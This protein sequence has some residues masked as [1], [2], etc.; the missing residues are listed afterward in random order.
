MTRAS[1]TF[2]SM[3]AV[4]WLTAYAPAAMAQTP[5]EGL[6]NPMVEVKYEPTDNPAFRPIRQRLMQR[7]VLEKL[8]IF[9][10]PLVLKQPLT[11][12]AAECGGKL[13]SPYASGGVVTLCYEYVAKVEKD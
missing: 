7:H 12:R 8:Q 13:F 2:T 9:L 10:G 4:A 1:S 5:P 6:R 11:V 3:I